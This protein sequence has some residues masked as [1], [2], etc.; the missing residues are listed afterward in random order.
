MSSSYLEAAPRLT[1]T[2][3]VVGSGGAMV[4]RGGDMV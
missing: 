3:T 4:G 2:I 1:G